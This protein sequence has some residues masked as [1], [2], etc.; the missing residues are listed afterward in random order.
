MSFRCDLHTHS[1]H[2][3]GTLSPEELVSAAARN[4]VNVLALT[5]H[6]TTDGVAEA[7]ERART[8]GIELLPGI[9][10]SVSQADGPLQI[11]ILGLGVDPEWAPL[12]AWVTEL[13]S[14]RVERM[15]KIVRRLNAIG[16]PLRFEDVSDLAGGRILARPHV[17]EALVRSGACSSRDQAFAQLLR[18]GRPAYVPHRGLDARS[19]IQLIHDAGGVASFAH[20]PRSIGLDAAGGLGVLVQQLCRLDLDAL[21]V[22]HPYHRPA[23]RRALRRLVKAHGLIA[24]GGSDFHGAATPGIELGKGRGDLTLGQEIY[25]PLV[26]RIAERRRASRRLTPPGAAG[27]LARPS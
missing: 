12:Q 3:D 26:A 15:R 6:D 16:I 9:E 25:A 19:A 5:D 13:Q 21:E 20:P 22:H 10:L 24:T 4:G 11:H 23:Q 2:S 18:R 7:T 14:S 8:L 1:I 27:T 17:A